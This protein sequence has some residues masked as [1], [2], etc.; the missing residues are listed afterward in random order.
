M[1]KTRDALNLA[2]SDLLPLLFEAWRQE[3][4][5]RFETTSPHDVDDLV[6]CR[7]RLLAIEEF[8]DYAV[9]NITEAVRASGVTNAPGSTAE[10]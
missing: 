7:V 10:H 1:D 3:C 8:R 6:V 2:A 4:F 5:A 9:A